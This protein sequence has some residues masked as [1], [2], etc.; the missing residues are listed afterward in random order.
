MKKKT[1]L[2]LIGDISLESLLALR[3]NRLRTILSILGITV[4]IAAVM[5]V[6]TVSRGGRYIIFSELETFGLKSLWVY[7]DRDDKDPRRSVRACTGMENADLAAVRASGCP[8]VQLITPL[9]YE[10]GPKMLVR[11]GARYA[12]AQV[13]GVGSDYLEINNDTLEYGRPLREEDIR[14]NR[15]VAVVG[16]EVVKDLFGVSGNPVGRDIR[17]GERKFTV[18]GVLTHKSRDFL[19]SIGSAGGQ[20]ANNRLLLPYTL[21]QQM[22]GTL[23]EINLFQAQAVSLEQAD[24]AVTQIKGVLKRRHGDHF[25]YKSDTMAQYIRTTNNILKWVTFIG[26]VAASVSLFVGGWES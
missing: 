20:N 21:Y 11:N 24:A 15:Q 18:I 23:K 16:T 19:A 9:V 14:R 1:G 10:K 6:G 17:V 25:T 12:N 2:R 8:S 13:T 5:A 26:V 7:R 22:T 4:G 3:D